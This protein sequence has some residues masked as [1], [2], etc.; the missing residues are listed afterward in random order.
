MHFVINKTTG[1]KFY[2]S[3]KAFLDLLVR[4]GTHIYE[5]QTIELNETEAKQ[6]IEDKLKY[7]AEKE[8]EIEAK[9]KQIQ[10]KPKR[11]R[12]RKTKT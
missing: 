9:L 10:D 4:R 3:R 1:E 12:Q 8:A 7:L 6:F 2:H 5:G 11:T